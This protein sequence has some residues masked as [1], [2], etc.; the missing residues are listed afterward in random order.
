MKGAGWTSGEKDQN[1]RSSA[2]AHGRRGKEGVRRRPGGVTTSAR[3]VW[4]PEKD[5][6]GG[7]GGGDGGLGGHPELRA[8]ARKSQRDQLR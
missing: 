8:R 5:A 2:Y 6:T 3:V 1:R 4:T 7:E